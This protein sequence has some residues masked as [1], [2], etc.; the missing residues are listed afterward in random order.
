MGYVGTT[1]DLN[2]LFKNAFGYVRPPYP[3]LVL[4]SKTVG[5]SPAGTAKA[6]RGAF[7]FSSKLGAE[8]TMPVALDGYQ[9]PQEPSV[10]IQGSK[11]VIQTPLNRGDKT[12]NV[13][14]EVNL[15]NYDIRIN[16]IILNEDDFEEYPEDAVRRMRTIC[17]KPGA[18]DI[19]NA[20]TK[21]WGISKVQI[22]NFQFFEVRGYVGAQA[23]MIECLSDQDFELDYR[24]NPER[25]TS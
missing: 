2:Q 6:L 21:I 23:F 12:Q 19:D 1:Y 20:L 11:N 18:I 10:F 13:L 22:V 15:N 25:V 7:N 24:D 3:T 4:E 8:Y 5:V 14:E 9:I 17:E 16:G